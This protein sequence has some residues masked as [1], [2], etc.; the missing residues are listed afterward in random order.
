MIMRK[1]LISELFAILRRLKVESEF[2]H[3]FICLFIDLKKINRKYTIGKY[4]WYILTQ[5]SSFQVQKKRK[6]RLA[7]VQYKKPFFFLF[8]V[9]K[10]VRVAHFK[11]N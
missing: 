7:T 6:R 3:F 11:F 1:E 8:S 5:G 4:N 9:H 2:I 10:L